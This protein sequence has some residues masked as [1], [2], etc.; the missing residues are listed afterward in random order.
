MENLDKY[1]GNDL[2]QELDVS[3]VSV[4][5]NRHTNLICAIH[6]WFELPVK[7]IIIIDWCSNIKFE[8]IIPT[9]LKYNPNYKKLRFLEL[10]D[11]I[12]GF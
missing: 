12:G 2:N 7:E 4:T 8:S 9:Y 6:T 10:K 11:M 5:M 3:I 1:F